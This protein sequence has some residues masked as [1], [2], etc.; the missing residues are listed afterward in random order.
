M[1]PNMLVAQGDKRIRI[2]RLG[3]HGAKITPVSHAYPLMLD[4]TGRTI[5]II[6]GGAVASRKATGVTSAG[7]KI[8][9]VISPEFRASFM[10]NVEKIHRHYQPGDLRDADLAF[11]ATDNE[12]V[13][14]AVVAEARQR[15]VLVCRADSGDLLSGDF[16]TP[17]M[18]ANGPVTVTV[19]AQSA[20]LAAVIRDS[21]QDSFDPRW[22]AMADA[23]Q[24]LRPII[25]SSGKTP[26]QRAVL[27]RALATPTARQILAQ[28]GVEALKN[29]ILRLPLPTL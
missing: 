17:A 14:D 9:R 15:K 5:V 13:N 20:A 3:F 16:T 21:L 18:F 24:I 22:I 8:V 12:E 27:F 6:G 29:W 11:A 25:K 7:A 23:M 26:S 28:G 2:S 1:L 19:S 4:L 10:T